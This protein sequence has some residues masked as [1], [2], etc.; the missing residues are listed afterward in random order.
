VSYTR[1]FD[2]AFSP[3]SQ[4][5]AIGDR[6]KITLFDTKTGLPDGQPLYGHGDWTVSSLD[7]SPDGRILASASWDKT[8]ILWD[9]ASR[10]QIGPPLTG[11]Y[12]TVRDV[13]F[14]GDG[15]SLVAT[16][17]Y[18]LFLRDVETHQ[19]VG[20]PINAYGGELVISRNR[21][22]IVT[23]LGGETVIWNFDPQV[24]QDLACKLARRNLTNEEWSFYLGDEPYHKTCPDFP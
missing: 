4:L 16:T 7:F 21:K 14:I 11:F 19:P 12:D 15:K 20:E 8:V 24:W 13:V 10:Q 2:L 23:H 6:G 18:G 5:L 3:D 1:A 17:T 9:V 22:Q